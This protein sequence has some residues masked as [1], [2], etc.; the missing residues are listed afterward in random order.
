MASNDKEQLESPAAPELICVRHLGRNAKSKHIRHERAGYRYSRYFLDDGTPVRR[1][2]RRSIVMDLEKFVANFGS[3]LEGATVGMLEVLEPKTMTP[4]RVADLPAYGAEIAA[5]I[6]KKV[7]IGDARQL[8]VDEFAYLHGEPS[9]KAPTT[10]KGKST[11]VTRKDV[12]TSAVIAAVDQAEAKKTGEANEPPSERKEE[13]EVE[14]EQP[15]EEHKPEA[16]V[17]TPPA[18]HVE[19]APVHKAGRPKRSK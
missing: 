6:G 12:D 13:K 9:V 16:P 5:K 7:E 3:I 11:E 19:P 1:K 8:L 10:P 15:V 18:A 4:V 17:T 14:K 2:G